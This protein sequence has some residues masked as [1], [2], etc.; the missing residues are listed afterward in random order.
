VLRVF[1]G[2]LQGHKVRF[3]PG[4]KE[5]GY[6]EQWSEPTDSIAWRVR[7]A[8]PASFNVTAVYDAPS[9]SAGGRFLVKA[10]THSLAGAVNEGKEFTQQLG[11][12]ELS[13]EEHLV[14]VVPQQIA[15]S[16]LMNLR[17]IALTPVDK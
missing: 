3:G 1:D 4:K 2:M 16:E 6:V 10:G 9:S 15:G 17:A 14:Q 12:V 5:N 7:V 13:T 8:Q 11:R